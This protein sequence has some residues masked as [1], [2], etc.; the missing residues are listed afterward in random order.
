MDDGTLERAA[1]GP[2]G[3]FYGAYP[4]LVVDVQDPDSQGRVKIR[5]PWSPD[6]G[7]SGY[8]VWARLATMM[9]GNNRGTWFIPDVDD[10]VLVMFEGGNPR[11]PYVIGALWNGSDAP[12]ES[13]SQDNNIKAIHSR[14]DIRITLDDT[15]GAVRLQLDT[16]GGHSITLSDGQT[17]ITIQDSTGNTIKME[18]SGISITTSGKVTVNA[19]TVEVTAGMVK[20]DAA[21]SKFSGM[22]TCDVLQ[23]NTVISTA[24]TPGVGNIW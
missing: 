21:M 1:T 9:A 18:P 4:A 22:V 8:E 5:L 6:T 17:T 13:M 23:S 14:Q 19:S 16:P 3:R 12:P 2:G 15:S 7:Q 20:V 11:R 10:E 24:Y